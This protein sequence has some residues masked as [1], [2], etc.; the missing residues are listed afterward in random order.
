MSSQV[1]IV[2]VTLHEPRFHGRPE[3]PPAPG[4]LFQALI[5]GASAVLGRPEIVATLR[6]LERLPPP[7]VAAPRQ[8][9]GKP[10]TLFV[11]NNDLDS[12]GGDPRKIEELRVSK[13]VTP[14]WLEPGVSFIYAWPFEDDPQHAE[15]IPEIARGLY[16]FG[17][18]VDMAYATADLVDLDGFE[19]LLAEYPG[20]VHRPGHGQGTRLACPTAGTF[21]S[22]QRRFE[23][24]RF[25]QIGGQRVFMQAPKI[26]L[27]DVAYDCPPNRYLFEL[28]RS[29]DLSKLAAVSVEHSLRLLVAVRDAAVAKLEAGLGTENMVEAALVGRRPSQDGGVKPASRVHI[30]PIPSIGHEK[31]DSGIRRLWIRVPQACPIAGE[32]IR[33]GFSGLEVSGYGTLVEASDTG[34]LKHYEGSGI[35]W[36]TVTPMALPAPRRRIDPAHVAEQRKPAEERAAEE[37]AARIAVAVALRQA[38]VRSQP[39]VI[40]VQRESFDAKLP[41]ADQFDVTPRFNKHA[42]WHVKVT[43]L[44]PE[45]GPIVA[46]D[47]RFMGL[48]LLAPTRRKPNVFAWTYSPADT[49]LDAELFTRALRRAVM[50]RVQAEMGKNPGTKRKQLSAFISGHADDGS[51]AQG[52]EHLHYLLDPDVP[53]LVVVAPVSAERDHAA[54]L[55]WLTAGLAELHTLHVAGD[56]SVRLQR[57]VVDEQDDPLLRASSAWESVTWYQVERHR[58][59]ANSASEAV[60][61]DV[62]NA[63]ARAGLP[64]PMGVDVVKTRATSDKGLEGQVRLEFATAVQGPLMLGRSR[65]RGGGLFRAR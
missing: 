57:A 39:S 47:G 58:R 51:P 6:W 1:I 44:E 24:Q 42:L 3:W 8:K 61:E 16:Q 29:D 59:D 60:A 33:W 30:I 22:S 54:D 40:D 7:V 50:A 19:Q 36:R 4:R 17:R 10:T 64:V 52:H 14:R 34:M 38:G 55:A 25:T 49:K 20:T 32:D 18:G 53:R 48:G 65:H 5:A 31:T 9:E 45:V 12:K 27:R 15:H 21:D 41:R 46:G 37:H 43:F 35:Q 62:R 26:L 28:R 2:R 56:V 63:L 13:L 23:A 11:P